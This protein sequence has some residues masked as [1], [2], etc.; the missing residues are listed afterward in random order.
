M[1]LIRTT[2]SSRK[3]NYLLFPLLNS[4]QLCCQSKISQSQI[5]VLIHKEIAYLKNK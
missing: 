5:H 3:K 4:L 1:I 2:I